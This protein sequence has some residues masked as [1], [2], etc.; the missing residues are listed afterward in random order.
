MDEVGGREV[1]TTGEAAELLRV[2]SK[3]ILQLAGRAALPG[4]KV[5]R[6]WRF[7]RS[8]LVT[9]LRSGRSEVARS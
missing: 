8:D 2:S 3:T 1:L 7:L 4:R 6:S 5:G 9:Y